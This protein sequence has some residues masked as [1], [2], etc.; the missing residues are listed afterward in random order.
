MTHRNKSP[1]PQALPKWVALRSLG[2]SR[3]DVPAG[4]YR[5]MMGNTLLEID[6]PDGLPGFGLVIAGQETL[7]FITSS[8]FVGHDWGAN[9][10]W[11][12]A[13]LHPDRVKRLINLSLP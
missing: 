6:T 7:V 9:V 4:N 5:T 13:L 12:L 1:E 10:V 11:G 3:S 2:L 8:G